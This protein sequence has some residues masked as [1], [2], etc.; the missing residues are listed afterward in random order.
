MDLGDVA[1]LRV[2]EPLQKERLVA[3]E[4]IQIRVAG[5]RELW[6][7]FVLNGKSQPYGL[8]PAGRIV[9]GLSKESLDHPLAGL[10]W[11][12]EK[13]KKYIHQVW[14]DPSARLGGVARQLVDAYRRYI[15][16]TVILSGP[17]SPDGLA[18]AKALKA[19]IMG[20]A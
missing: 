16:K 10:V 3:A 2:R 13:R 6:T 11:V 19:K 12:Q 17:F 8:L 18:L 1:R 9:V 5:A 4:P 7:L 20:D 15:T 14:V